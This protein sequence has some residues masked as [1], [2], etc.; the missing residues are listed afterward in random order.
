MR[1]KGAAWWD[2]LAQATGDFC[3]RIRESSAGCRWPYSYVEVFMILQ[4]KI[5]Y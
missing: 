3:F 2:N 1:N 4:L 5:M